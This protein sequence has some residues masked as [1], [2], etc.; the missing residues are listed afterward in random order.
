MVDR[1][2]TG[3]PLGQSGH[4]QDAPTTARGGFV[5][6]GRNRNCW[7][8]II[9]SSNDVIHFSPPLF[10]LVSISLSIYCHL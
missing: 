1:S 8:V 6:G 3:R 5:G 2:S 10:S 9:I 7:L 4:G